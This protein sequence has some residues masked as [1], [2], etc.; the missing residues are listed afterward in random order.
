MTEPDNIVLEHFRHIRGVVDRID[1][2]P[3]ELTT[4]V[5]RVEINPAQAQVALAEHSTRFD[6]IEI[7]LDW[8]EK[9]LDLVDH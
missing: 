4:R 3:S 8:I 2:R 7:R 1:N 5:G 9:R 6:G